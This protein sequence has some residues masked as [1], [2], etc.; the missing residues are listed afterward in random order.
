MAAAH[1]V[2]RPGQLLEAFSKECASAM[3]GAMN[4][5]TLVSCQAESTPAA[6]GL[7]A[8]RSATTILCISCSELKMSGVSTVLRLRTW[9]VVH[10][11][12]W[13]QHVEVDI[14]AQALLGEHPK[15]SDARLGHPSGD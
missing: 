9:E 13:V 10:R 3:H 12:V 6:E 15:Y 7:K 8:C 5:V 14:M 2:R 11:N 4:A 1:S